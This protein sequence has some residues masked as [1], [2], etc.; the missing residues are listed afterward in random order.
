MQTPDQRRLGPIDSGVVGAGTIDGRGGE[1][2]TG[3]TNSWWTLEELYEGQLAAPRLIQVNRR[4]E[5]RALSGHA[6][7]RAQVPRRHRFDRRLQGLGHHHQRAGATRATPTASI[8]ASAKN[9]TITRSYINTG[10]D[11]IAIKAGS[12]GPSTNITISHNH[13]YRGHGVSIGS[14]T[15]G[16]ASAIRVF[17]LSIEGAD[18]GLRI[19]SNASRGGLVH[20]IEYKDVCIRN[21]RHPLVFDSF[22]SSATGTAIP[23][24]RD[25]VVN[26]VHVLGAGGINTFRGWDAAHPVGIT[27]NNV[28]FDSAPTTITASNANIVLGPG[29]VNITPAGTGVT[30]TDQVTGSATPRVCDD[31]WVTF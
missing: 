5:L 8:P 20:D 31:A 7:E 13:F 9:V 4:H 2:L 29:G 12:T 15:D 27:L 3:D 19:K 26:N 25:I 1:V 16:G 24:F 18:N 11:N 14:E 17:D 28:F 23:D 22:Y 21:S 30:V 10:D 6:Q